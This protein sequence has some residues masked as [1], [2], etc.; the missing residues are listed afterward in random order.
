MNHPQISSPRLL[1]K[2]PADSSKNVDRLR[3]HSSGGQCALQTS[4]S[5]VMALAVTRGEDEHFFSHSA[6]WEFDRVFGK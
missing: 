2:G 6:N 5:R 1:I 3:I 4:G